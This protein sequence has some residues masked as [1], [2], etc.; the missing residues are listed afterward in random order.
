MPWFH[1]LQWVLQA[2]FSRQTPW[3]AFCKHL[4]HLPEC[5]CSL[6]VN[7]DNFHVLL[8]QG[9]CMLFGC[10]DDYSRHKLFTPGV[11]VNFHSLQDSAM[12]ENRHAGTLY[13]ATW[14]HYVWTLLHILVVNWCL[15]LTVRLSLTV[16]STKLETRCQ[17]YQRTRYILFASHVEVFE[18]VSHALVLYSCSSALCFSG[19]SSVDVQGFDC[20]L[21]LCSLK[22]LKSSSPVLELGLLLAWMNLRLQ[23]DHSYCCESHEHWKDTMYLQKITC[24]T[25]LKQCPYKTLLLH[26][27]LGTRLG[28]AFALPA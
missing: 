7:Y 12:W 27:R 20:F 2:K 17:R 22:T 18:I 28:W 13:P 21:Q 11:T 5:T 6:Q 26:G 10:D 8:S 23:T 4:S 1:V 15:E 16:S 24:T 9:K 3:G 14:P 19:L 25:L